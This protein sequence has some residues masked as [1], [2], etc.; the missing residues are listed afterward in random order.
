MNTTIYALCH[1][2]T[3]EVRYV[4][5]T[6]NFKDRM[7]GHLKVR[8]KLRSSN[9][10]KSLPDKPVAIILEE[11]DKDWADAERF[12]IAYFKFLG[13]RLT[14]STSGGEGEV[15]VKLSEDTKKKLA[16]AN[17]GKKQS[18]ETK[19]KRS[20]SLKGRTHSDHTK[21]LISK[22]K[23]GLKWSEE[24]KNNKSLSMQ[25]TCSEAFSKSSVG[26]APW[27]K[28]LPMLPHVKVA[29]INANKTR[30]VS[31]ET[32]LLMSKAHTG[33]VLTKE[34]RN[35]IAESKRGTFAS[36]ET[37]LKL[38]ESH[39]GIILSPESKQKLSDAIRNSWIKRKL[40]GKDISKK[41]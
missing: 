21:A 16:L 6:V 38:S 30:I 26:R 41:R 4:G 19:K 36:K 25:G 40:E 3:N 8:N 20:A 27:N 13:A 1:P 10:I 37:L 15:G 29:I 32:K 24:S 2:L 18:E 12:W 34:H 7:K 9:W 17:I 33:K 22:N 35:K 31:E 5:K 23:T 39:K 11:V 14:N 28:G